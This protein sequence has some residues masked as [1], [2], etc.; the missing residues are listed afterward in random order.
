MRAHY[1]T[2]WG[3]FKYTRAD[4]IW[5]FTWPL[6]VFVTNKIFVTWLH[7]LLW[8]RIIKEIRHMVRSNSPY[9]KLFPSSSNDKENIIKDELPGSLSKRFQYWVDWVK[10]NQGSSTNLLFELVY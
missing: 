9:G 4:E 7:Y 2:N 3:I 5:E 10:K 6:L 1:E 8:I